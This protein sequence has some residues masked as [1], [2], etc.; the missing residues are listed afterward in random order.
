ME[1]RNAVV[2]RR[3]AVKEKASERRN[4]LLA[5]RD[6]QSFMA[7]AEDMANW[8]NEKYKLAS[9]ESYRDLSNLERKLQKQ[10]AFVREL[11]ANEGR[12]MGLRKVAWTNKSLYLP[13]SFF[14]SSR[15]IKSFFF[16]FEF[17]LPRCS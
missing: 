7:D 4:Q 11:R 17:R 13:N 9:D 5:S 8:M 2:A 12:L 15:L 14:F 3:Q 16:F 10:E 1:R 6:F